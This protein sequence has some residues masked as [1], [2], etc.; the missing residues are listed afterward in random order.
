MVA[1]QPEIERFKYIQR[2]TMIFKNFDLTKYRIRIRKHALKRA[3]QRGIDPDLIYCTIKTGKII[4][5]GKNNLKF[6][7]KFK[8]FCIICVDQ[9]TDDVIKIVTVELKRK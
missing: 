4:R 2:Y 7:K 3:K 6:I 5:F 1:P 8:G 9:I